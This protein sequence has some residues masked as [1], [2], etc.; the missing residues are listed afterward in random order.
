MVDR[1]A[2]RTESGSPADFSQEYKTGFKDGWDSIESKIRNAIETYEAV[3]FICEDCG[4]LAYMID[5]GD[6]LV[7]HIGG[8]LRSSG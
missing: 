8:R 5:P 2:G 7:T 6:G 3:I 1:N 4:K